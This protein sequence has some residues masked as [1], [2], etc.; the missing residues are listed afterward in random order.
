MPVAQKIS[1]DISKTENEFRIPKF[2]DVPQATS[3]I[4]E[5]IFKSIEIV[6]ARSLKDPCYVLT[7]LEDF[8]R[9]NVPLYN[10]FIYRTSGLRVSKLATYHTKNRTIDDLDASDALELGENLLLLIQDVS[11]TVK[12]Q[13]WTKRYRL[14][15]L[16]TGTLETL[17][18]PET[19]ERWLN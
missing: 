8:V 16:P 15:E 1:E 12:N 19:S 9:H 5:F 14:L 10:Y 3:N 7:W 13:N 2:S 4:S 6:D 11:K 18:M 17:M